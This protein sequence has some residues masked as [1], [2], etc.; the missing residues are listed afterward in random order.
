MATMPVS[1]MFV[2]TNVL[3]FAHIETAPLHVC[4]LAALTQAHESGRELWISRQV[5]REFLAVTSRPQLFLRPKPP[6]LLAKLVRRFQ[7][8]FRVA[9]DNAEVTE[10][11]VE[12]LGEF[13]VG[14]RQVHDANIVATM[15]THGIPAILT[16]NLSDFQRFAKYIVPCPLEEA[17]PG[18][19]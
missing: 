8:M 13:S 5:I 3:V 2:D 16:H 1:A 10:R 9:E 4:A 17:V 11:L 19:H 15:I 18:T 12:L 14:G 7:D 6:E